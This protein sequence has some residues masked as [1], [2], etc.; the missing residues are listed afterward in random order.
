MFVQL[1]L[2]AVVLLFFFE[3]AASAVREPART[4]SCP[5]TIHTH[6]TDIETVGR[7]VA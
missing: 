1:A 3:S 4:F 6:I 2:G 7:R 5:S